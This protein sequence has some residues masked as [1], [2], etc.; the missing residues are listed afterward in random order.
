[1]PWMLGP[2]ALLEWARGAPP[3]RRV[4]YLD[5]GVVGGRSQVI[6]GPSLT[7]E[8]RQ[9]GRKSCLRFQI[10]KEVQARTANA[11]KLERSLGSEAAR[12]VGRGCVSRTQ[13]LGSTSG[14]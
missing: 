9:S 4:G 5:G 8:G 7:G 14:P 11:T 3:G 2:Q 1:M 10:S 13:D 12:G 6:P